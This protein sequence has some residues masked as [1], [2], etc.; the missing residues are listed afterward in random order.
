MEELL[1]A[2]EGSQVAQALR[3]SRWGYAAVN[4]VH[5]LAVALLVGAAVPMSL[6]LLGVWRERVAVSALVPVLATVA[7]LGAGVAIATGS[8]L[9]SVRA[10]EYAAVPVLWLKLALIATG[11][12]SA[13]A[14]HRRYGW[15]LVGAGR[16]RLAAAG[17]VSLVCWLGALTAGRMI[18]FVAD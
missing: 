12:V 3:Y 16:G 8:L 7:A 17:A 14:L 9:F 18:A 11:L 15:A 6:R 1:A 5:V 2:I 4:T 13:L 10:G